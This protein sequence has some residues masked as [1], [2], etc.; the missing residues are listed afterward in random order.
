VHNQGLAREGLPGLLQQRGDVH[1]VAVRVTAAGQG[2][3][4]LLTAPP[5]LRRVARLAPLAATEGLERV[6]Q[7]CQPRLG[8]RDDTDLGRVVLPDLVR[9]DVEV[10]QPGAL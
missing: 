7:R 1:G 5:D 3:Q 4:P 9:I 8:V 10:D 6:R 2:G